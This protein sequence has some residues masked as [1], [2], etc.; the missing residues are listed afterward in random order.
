MAQV[1]VD[2]RRI[3]QIV[4]DDG[5]NVGQFERIKR[6]HDPLRRLSTLES[7]DY[8]LQQH[9]AFADAENPLRIFMQGDR[10]C[11]WLLI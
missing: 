11:E 1:L 5:I 7:A 2:R 8:K 3:R 10:K 4:A 9:S 6:L